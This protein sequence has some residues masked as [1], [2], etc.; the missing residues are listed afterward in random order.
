MAL[1]KAKTRFEGICE[2]AHSPFRLF[3]NETTFLHRPL[4]P[5]PDNEEAAG[6]DQL[7]APIPNAA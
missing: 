5:L 3:K 4:I 1:I 6:D 7:D 2:V